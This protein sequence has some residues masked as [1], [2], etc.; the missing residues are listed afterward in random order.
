MQVPRRDR[1][2]K[3]VPDSKALPLRHDHH[4]SNPGLKGFDSAKVSRN[5]GM[6]DGDPINEADVGLCRYHIVES[7][8]VMLLKKRPVGPIGFVDVD[9]DAFGT[10]KIPPGELSGCCVINPVRLQRAQYIAVAG[11]DKT[12]PVILDIEIRIGLKSLEFIS[13][14]QY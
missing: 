14:I 1:V 11:Q 9:F 2:E 12:L 4:T 7:Q 8:I 10:L 5:P 6:T 13:C 3:A